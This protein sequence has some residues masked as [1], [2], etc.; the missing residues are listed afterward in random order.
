MSSLNNLDCEKPVGRESVLTYNEL[1]YNTH[2]VT[3]EG[4]G[5]HLK[6]YGKPIFLIH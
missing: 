3:F 1:H 4:L 2:T 5:N 6:D